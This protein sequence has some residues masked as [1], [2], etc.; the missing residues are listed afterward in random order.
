MARSKK[1]RKPCLLLLRLLLALF[2]SFNSFLADD[3]ED[4]ADEDVPLS[5]PRLSCPPSSFPHPPLPS[6]TFRLAISLPRLDTCNTFY[7]DL[8]ISIFLIALPTT[9]VT[10]AIFSQQIFWSR[11]LRGDGLTRK[12]V[13]VYF[14]DWLGHQATSPNQIKKPCFSWDRRGP[15]KK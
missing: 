4:L 9:E 13:D 3:P 1:W 5:R 7:R 2:S 12:H 11:N 8:P 6:P 10:N 15:K 14:S